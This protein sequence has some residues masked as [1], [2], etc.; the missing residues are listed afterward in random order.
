MSEWNF[1]LMWPPQSEGKTRCSAG[2]AVNCT[3]WMVKTEVSMLPFVGPWK[4]S[5]E[6]SSGHVLVST[7]KG[8]DD[9]GENSRFV[10][11][12]P[13][14][15]VVVP[16]L[17]GGI[18]GGPRA[19][20][21]VAGVTNAE[22][23]SRNGVGR[24]RPLNAGASDEVTVT[25]MLRSKKRCP[26]DSKSLSICGCDG[27]MLVIHGRHWRSGGGCF[28]NYTCT[29]AWRK[30]SQK[31]ANKWLYPNRD[32]PDDRERELTPGQSRGASYP[33]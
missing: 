25:W 32:C 17:S 19:R 14:A 33:S 29:Y 21:A 27:Y 5:L 9:S 30:G 10:K 11:G 6:G 28:M 15:G 8:Y 3:S 31:L 4:T 1:K 2:G 18:R 7:N 23:D 13:V 16:Q 12:C 22:L 26:R 24:R 20:G